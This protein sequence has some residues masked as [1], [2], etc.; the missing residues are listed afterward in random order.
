MPIDGPGADGQLRGP[1]KGDARTSVQNPRAIVQELWRRPGPRQVWWRGRRWRTWLCILRLGKAAQL[2]TQRSPRLELR[3]HSPAFDVS[4]LPGLAS[5]PV[6]SGP[7]PSK[8][9]NQVGP[10]K[11][12]GMAAV[13]AVTLL[14][15]GAPVLATV[16]PPHGAGLALS[17]SPKSSA[18]DA[19]LDIV[20]SGLRPSVPV[21]LEVSSIDARGQKWASST[22]YLA[23]PDG[24]V[25]PV[26]SPAVRGS[27]TGLDAMGPVDFMTDAAPLVT[28][29]TPGRLFVLL[30][31]TTGAV[32]RGQSHWGSSS[33]FRAGEP[34]P[35]S[36]SGAAHH[37][38]SL[39]S[40]RAWRP[41]ASWDSSSSPRRGGPTTSPSWSSTARGRACT[42]LVP[43]SICTA[44]RP[45]TLPIG[46]KRG[47]PRH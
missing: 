5:S 42:P 18:P 30:A 15:A 9:F 8:A 38:Q 40:T 45:W 22:I 37:G 35:R 29:S 23:S 19:P 6:A 47:C 12:R 3:R 26:T 27:Y 21:T 17:V 44:T 36:P 28:T 10:C 11:G 16:P 31:R 4:C 1:P 32:A 13:L 7:R 33:A 24:V 20:A 14:M 39:R 43:S 46:V 25:N 34:A 41:K 2:R